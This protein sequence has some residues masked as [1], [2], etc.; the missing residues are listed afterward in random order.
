MLA[1]LSLASEFTR[2][3]FRPP[4]VDKPKSYSARSRDV[5]QAVDVTGGHKLNLTNDQIGRRAGRARRRDRPAPG[6]APPS[7]PAALDARLRGAEQFETD[8]RRA[9]AAERRHDR[10][11]SGMRTRHPTAITYAVAG[12]T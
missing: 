12:G 8:R 1:S 9:S 7:A 6:L 3:P 4:P 10:C 11:S 5:G 2:S